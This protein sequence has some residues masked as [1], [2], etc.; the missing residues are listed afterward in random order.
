M[1]PKEVKK[2]ETRENKKNLL[3]IKE[4]N[5]HEFNP[6]LQKELFFLR[7]EQRITSE[8]ITKFELCRVISIRAKQI[9]KDNIVFTDVSGLS[10]PIKMAEKEVYD[11]KCPLSIIRKL[12][13]NIAEKWDINE[14][15]L[16]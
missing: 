2:K 10:D 16:I 13:E 9:E 8:I 11:R 6:I 7:P 12:N 14:M 1:P 4:S 15:I 5:K 3:D